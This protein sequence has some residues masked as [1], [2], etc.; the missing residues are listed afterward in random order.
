VGT[1]YCY[2][3]KFRGREETFSTSETIELKADEFT[4][5]GMAQEYAL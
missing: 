4:L 1:L 5:A 3:L 2:L